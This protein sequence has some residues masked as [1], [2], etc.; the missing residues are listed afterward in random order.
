MSETSFSIL[1]KII[2]IPSI[3]CTLGVIIMILS[4]KI[5]RSPQHL[6]LLFLSLNDLIYYISILLLFNDDEII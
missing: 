1:K 5:K 3:I 2:F 4:Y 6:N